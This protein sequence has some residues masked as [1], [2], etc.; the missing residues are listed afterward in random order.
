M[1]RAHFRQGT[2]GYRSD[3]GPKS[4]QQDA[5]P[6]SKVSYCDNCNLQAS[7]IGYRVGEDKIYAR[8]TRKLWALARAS[9]LPNVNCSHM[10]QAGFWAHKFWRLRC[11]FPQKMSGQ[12]HMTFPL[13]GLGKCNVSHKL[14]IS[15][16]FQ[17]FA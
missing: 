15:K 2:L 11:P 12:C 3:T 4:Y 8:R 13:R 5:G 9:R 10:S 6:Q 7:V 17:N 16:A 14:L 1:A